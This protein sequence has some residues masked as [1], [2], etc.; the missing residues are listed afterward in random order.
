[1][2]SYNRHCA[3]CTS[4]PA[5]LP[6]GKHACISFTLVQKLVF[7]PVALTR[8][9]NITRFGLP[10]RAKFSHLPEHKCGVYSLEIVKI[11]NFAHK[12]R[13]I[14]TIFTNF[15]P[16]VCVCTRVFFNLVVFGNSAERQPSYNHLPSMGKFLIPPGGE[17]TDRI[18]NSK[19]VQKWDG[20]PLS[21]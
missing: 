1:M 18:K 10:C 9:T 2:L 11:W 8:C 20:P 4:L 5:G 3:I 7:R 14:C 17:T 16:F 15:S 12:G 21:P 13:I 19:V 6:A